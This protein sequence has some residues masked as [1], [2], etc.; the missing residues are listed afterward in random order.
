MAIITEATKRPVTRLDTMYALRALIDKMYEETREA[1]K[2]GQPVAWCMAGAPG[3]FLSAMGIECVFP[4]NYGTICAAS[5]VA[6]AF[7]ERADAEGFPTHMCGYARN[8]L[9]YTAR[10]REL[11][12]D[13]PPEAPDGGMPKPTLLVASEAG[14]DA[15]YKWFQA[16]GRYFDV[17][18]WVV[19]AL[20]PG[21]RE[22]LIEGAYE[23][24][25]NFLVN[26]LREFTTFLKRLVGRKMDWD[27][28]NE[29][30][31]DTIEM[32]SE[33]RKARPCPMHIRDF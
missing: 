33:L 3:T 1:K 14:C 4:E 27:K 29:I 6:P 24:D 2:A 18:V 13:I 22:S 15:R 17:P 19:E 10:M 5:G 32:E 31:D 20:S 7:L 11:T 30:I 12:W 21:L 8:C 23:R 28:F 25:V 16:L 26:E 9:G